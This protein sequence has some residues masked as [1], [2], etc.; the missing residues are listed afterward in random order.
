MS[1]DMGQDLRRELA[2][3][4]APPEP[5]R[6]EM[7]AEIRREL[8][9]EEA[10]DAPAA[11]RDRRARR[12]PA[13]W[14]WAAAALLVVG[15]GIGRWSAPGG[16]AG[17]GPADDEPVAGAARGAGS[18]APVRRAAFQHLSAA[19][20][21]LTGVRADARR[22]DMADGAASWARGL[23]TET[24]LL[25]DS[26][27]ARDPE[28]GPLLTDLE[29]ILAQVTRAAEAQ[30]EAGGRGR[31]ELELLTRGIDES[32]MNL[33]IDAVLPASTGSTGA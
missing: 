10:G 15:I 2:G 7:W 8:R 5:P 26:S 27:V 28:L 30:G 14:V 29:L 9:R 17:G 16:P 11:R 21:F 20:S 22:G 31:E 33:R 24:R 18:R 23:L 6:E 25:L 32:D 1:D 3:Y 4:H 19:E 13:P 12:P